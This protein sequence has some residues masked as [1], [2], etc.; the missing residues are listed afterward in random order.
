MTWVTG[1]KCETET[2]FTSGQRKAR[3]QRKH[4]GQGVEWAFID[5]TIMYDL[6]AIDDRASTIAVGQRK[7]N[8]SR[9][10]D[11]IGV[12]KLR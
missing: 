5:G 4:W 10:R 8:V 6:E 2:G 12:L 1:D 3:R 7:E 9:I 11:R